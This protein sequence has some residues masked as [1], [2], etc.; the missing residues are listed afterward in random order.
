MSLVGL[1]ILGFTVFVSKLRVPF[2]SKVQK[3][4]I[5]GDL[6]HPGGV[7]HQFLL[8]FQTGLLLKCLWQDGVSGMSMSKQ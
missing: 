5:L 8:L 1:G 6:L 2:M 4:N 3:R 7:D